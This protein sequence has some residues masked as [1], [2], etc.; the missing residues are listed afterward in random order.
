MQK[1][2]V[3][4]ENALKQ[5]FRYFIGLC[6]L[7]AFAILSWQKK[8]M[9]KTYPVS[10]TQEQWGAR[11]KFISDAKEVMRKSS[12]PGNIISTI[13]DSLDALAKEINEQVGSELQREAVKA[14][15]DTTHKPAANK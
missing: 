11:L 9:R 8:E 7:G 3:Q 1:T 4:T 5:K 14:K 12:Y 2:F 15:A 10:L 13:S 6:L